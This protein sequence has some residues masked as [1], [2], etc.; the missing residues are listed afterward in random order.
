[1]HF[2]VI[3]GIDLIVALMDCGETCQVEVGPRFSYGSQGNGKDIP[4]DATILY[5]IELLEVNKPKD[6]EDVG[7]DERLT[8]G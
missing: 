1:M 6:L 8:I 4:P 5:S 2:Q 7:I 3:Q